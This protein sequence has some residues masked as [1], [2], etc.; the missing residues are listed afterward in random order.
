MLRKEVQLP[1]LPSPARGANLLWMQ[2]VAGSVVGDARDEA[3]K[4][5]KRSKECSDARYHCRTKRG[6]HKVT[7]AGPGV[8]NARKAAT[9]DIT[10]GSGVGGAGNKATQH[11]KRRK[12][13]L[14]SMFENDDTH[15]RR[16]SLNS[17]MHVAR[18]R[19]GVPPLHT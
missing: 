15:A 5:M 11:M 19:K 13:L 8:G 14:E 9:Q 6:R 10:A 12:R 18:F 16:R 17:Q 1:Q 4:G 7:Q 2:F 3:R